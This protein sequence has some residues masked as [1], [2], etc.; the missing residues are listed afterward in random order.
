MQLS[1]DRRFAVAYNAVQQ[2]AKMVLACEGYRVSS[3]KGGHHATTFEAV[4][5]F[6]GPAHQ[7]LIDYFDT[8]R[9]KRNQ[10]NYDH[11]GIIS[12]S[13]AQEIVKSADEFRL[14][15]DAWIQ[16]NHPHLN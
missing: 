6:L 15:V 9:Q 12:D 5:L 4:A 11:A 2:L 14:L 16:Q 1:S 13:E 7:A 8:C 3:S 10:V